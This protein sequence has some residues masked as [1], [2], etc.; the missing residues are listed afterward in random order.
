MRWPLF[1]K[2]KG[3]SSKFPALRIQGKRPHVTNVPKRGNFGTK[4]VRASWQLKISG[5][6][7]ALRQILTELTAQYE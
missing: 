6:S 1:A 7:R 2:M 5:K 3:R 4:S